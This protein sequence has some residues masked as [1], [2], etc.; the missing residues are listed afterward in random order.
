MFVILF[1]L[2]GNLITTTNISLAEKD[3]KYYESLGY[4]VWDIQTEEKIIALTFDD[5]PHPIYTKQV[6]DLLKQHEAKGT[7]FVVGKQAEA[8]PDLITRMEQEGHAIGNH[9]YT[10]PSSRSVPQIMKEIDQANEALVQILG[11]SPKLFRPV[12]G[13]YTE[14]LVTEVV[15]EGYQMVMWSWHQDTEDWKDPGVNAIVNKVLKG[16]AEG[17]VILFHDGGAKRDQTVQALSIILPE[18]IKQGFTFVTV[19]ELLE[20][21]NE[22]KAG[23]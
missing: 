14:Q 5:G 19:A 18:L 2:G 6:L 23:K 9:T 11:Y 7:F 20:L 16:A 17:N 13:Y 8:N 21:Q 12:E 1:L 4:V 10:H 22:I 15:K 3:R